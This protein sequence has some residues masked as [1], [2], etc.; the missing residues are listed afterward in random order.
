M[1]TEPRVA[2][3]PRPT[4]SRAGFA[5]VLAIALCAFLF[6]VGPA[7]ALLLHLAT[8]LLTIALAAGLIAFAAFRIGTASRASRP[9]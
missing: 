7:A 2:Y 5:V 9:H 3:V 1:L 6:L 8:I 4:R